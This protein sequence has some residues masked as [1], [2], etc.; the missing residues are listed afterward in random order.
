MQSYELILD[1][2][3]NKIRITSGDIWSYFRELNTVTT[4]Y[5][6]KEFQIT[7]IVGDAILGIPED[8]YQKRSIK[9]GDFLEVWQ[10]WLEIR[11]NKIGDYQDISRNASYVIAVI[12]TYLKTIQSKYGKD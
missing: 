11:S 12:E 2:A 6:K 7:G 3:G 10:R 5:D 9:Y 4:L 8:S 1:D